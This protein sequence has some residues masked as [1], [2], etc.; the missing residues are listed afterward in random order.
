MPQQTHSHCGGSW[1]QS[2]ELGLTR[3]KQA[4]LKPHLVTEQ[5]ETS[6]WKVDQKWEVSHPLLG[7]A[8]RALTLDVVTCCHFCVVTGQM[9]FLAMG[10]VCTGPH[11]RGGTA[12]GPQRSV[13]L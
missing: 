9:V 13:A 6:R 5:V 2:Q 7:T 4:G 3:W 8:Q 12:Q 1:P 10:F 11:D